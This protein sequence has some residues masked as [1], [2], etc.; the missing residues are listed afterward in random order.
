MKAAKL[1]DE[2]A[3]RIA[4]NLR[5]NNS[6]ILTVGLKFDGTEKFPI[7][8]IASD[9][10]SLDFDINFS[11]NFINAICRGLIISQF[12]LAS[13]LFCLLFEIFMTI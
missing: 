6:I 7:L 12:I 11:Q 9:C 13:L 8:K 10:Y 3:C 4:A 1:V 5:E 2:N